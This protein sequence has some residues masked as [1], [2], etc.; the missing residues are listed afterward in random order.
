VVQEKY[1]GEQAC[2]KRGNSGGD[3]DDDDNDDDNDDDDSLWVSSCV[4]FM[5]GNNSHLVSA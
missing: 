4:K 3:D 2:G 1:Q 5:A